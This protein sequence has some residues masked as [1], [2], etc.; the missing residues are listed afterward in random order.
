MTEVKEL[1]IVLDLWFS[2]DL[3]R[4]DMICS[5]QRIAVTDEG[6]LTFQDD[7]AGFNQEY[8]E[9]RG[10]NRGLTDS[11]IFSGVR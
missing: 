5:G 3:W 11:L 7:F 10:L 4:R 1:L 2:Q 8:N 6:N 9:I